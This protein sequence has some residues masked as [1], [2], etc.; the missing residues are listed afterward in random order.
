[1]KAATHFTHFNLMK[2]C[3]EE[4]FKCHLKFMRGDFKFFI[5]PQES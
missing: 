1:M 4:V 3:K 5:S 2:V